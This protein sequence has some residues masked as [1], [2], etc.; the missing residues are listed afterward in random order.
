MLHTCIIHQEEPKPHNATR[1]KP[2]RS[3][4]H[5]R[6]KVGLELVQPEGGHDIY[7]PFSFTCSEDTL[8][9]L[10]KGLNVSSAHHTKEAVDE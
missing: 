4:S 9:N 1:K 7:R 3:L 5:Q 10:A 2:G 8:Y 6:Q